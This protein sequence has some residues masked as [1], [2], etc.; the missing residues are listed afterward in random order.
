MSRRCGG[1]RL[2]YQ[3]FYA[4]RVGLW[5]K[6]GTYGAKFVPDPVHAALWP[7]PAEVQPGKHVIHVLF[8]SDL[9]LR[10]TRPVDARVSPQYQ[11][12]VARTR[13]RA[14]LGAP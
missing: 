5:F 13:P 11:T 14:P 12:G 9:A 1:I 6:T 8:G 4:P 10:P 2:G 7:D 3:F